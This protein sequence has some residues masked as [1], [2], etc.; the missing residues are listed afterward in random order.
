MHIKRMFLPLALIIFFV[1]FSNYA[2]AHK[3]NLFCYFEDEFLIGEGYY[4]G[5]RPAQNAGIGI[6]SLKDNTLVAETQTDPEGKFKV[7]LDKP[8]AVK[9][10]MKAGQGHRCEFIVDQESPVSG[11]SSEVSHKNEK[12]QGEERERLIKQKIRP[13]DM[14][15]MELEKQQSEPNVISIISGIGFIIGIFSVIYFIKRKHAL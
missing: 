3:V 14:R 5:G 11:D 12:I 15:I 6:Y 13:L 10:V 9:V 8:D 1:G 7:R 2:F 4:S